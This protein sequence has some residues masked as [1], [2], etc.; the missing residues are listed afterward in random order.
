MDAAAYA[1]ISRRLSALERRVNAVFRTGKVALVQLT[2]YRVRVDVGPDD[3]GMPVITDLLPVL[4]L[5]SGEVREWDPL[6]RGER[7][8]VLAPGGEDTAAFVLPALVSTEFEAVSAEAGDRVTRYDALGGPGTEVGR[9][10]TVRGADAAASSQRI[11][12]G[13]CELV[14][15]GD[16]TVRLTNGAATI[17]LAGGAVTVTSG[18]LTHNGVNVGDDHTHGAVLAGPS[19]TSGPG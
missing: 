8:S 2:P 5:R 1:L 13:P 11:A 3:D 16:G 4:V 17:T 7:V 14:L 9:M 10:H 19:R 18:S 15:E 12:L 6:T